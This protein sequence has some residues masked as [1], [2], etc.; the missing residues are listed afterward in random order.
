MKSSGAVAAIVYGHIEIATRKNCIKLDT[1]VI[2]V[3]RRKS[4]CVRTSHIA[5]PPPKKQ[6]FE[7][8]C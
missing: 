3:V 4:V 7:F 1:V 5:P 8:Q 6:L 2:R